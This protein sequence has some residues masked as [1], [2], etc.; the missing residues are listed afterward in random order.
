MIM[1]VQHQVK[2]YGEWKKMFDSAIAMR[3]ASG[4][5]SVQVLRDMNDPNNLTLINKWD[6]MENA[7]KFVQSPDLQTAM[8]KGGVMGMPV[9]HFLMEA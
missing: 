2:D 5:I 1:I 8:E 6:S 7:Q 3:K 4:E 9:V